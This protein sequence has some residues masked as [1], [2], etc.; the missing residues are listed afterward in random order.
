MF[1]YSVF[2]ILSNLGEV[3]VGVAIVYLIYSSVVYVPNSRVGIKEKLWSLKG[4]VENG[5]I[6]L[7]G[8][9]GYEAKLLRGGFHFL[10]PFMYKIHREDLVLVPQGQIAY[11]FARDGK[12]L[13]P[14][15]VLASNETSADYEN[16]QHYLEQGGQ[17]GPQRKV[18]REGT[19]AI[20]TVQFIV[21]THDRVYA[22]GLSESDQQAIEATKIT[23]QQRNGFEPLVIN[24]SDDKI[25][26]VTVHDGPSLRAGELIAPVVGQLEQE[27]QHNCFQ[28]PDA[29]ISVGGFRGRQLQVLVDGTY[30]LN[31]LFATVDLISKSTIQMGHVGVVISYTGDAGH[32]VSGDDYQHGELVQ[33]GTKGVW[34]APLL[35][36]KYPFNTFAGAIVEVPTTNFILK[37]ESQTSGSNFDKNLK[38]VSLITKDAFEPWLPLS[39]VV[40]IDYKKAPKV[41]QRFG[42]IQ[43]LVEQTLD[44]MV[45][46]YFKNTAQTKT[47][48]ELLQERDKIQE[49]ALQDMRIKFAAYNLELQ[50][51]L[52]G[53]PRSKENDNQIETILA[54]LRARQVAREQQETYRTQEEAAKT[55][56]SLR[57]ARAIAEKQ[58]TL[59]ESHIAIQIAENNG[60]AE[61]NKQKRQG[62]ADAA[63]VLAIAEAD[64][65][66]IRITGEA[67]A[68]R[69]ELEGAA[70]AVA[71]EQQVKAFGG[72]ELRLAQE[73]A[74]QIIK[75]IAD[76]KIP[77]VPHVLV[78]G[79]GKSNAFEAIAGMV[80]SGQNLGGVFSQKQT[81]AD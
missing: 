10:I 23:I 17:K 25:A 30:Y 15:Q 39:I 69:I 36:G 54:Q 20:N 8:E 13:A 2:S 26:I 29:F 19:Y 74:S 60:L 27:S 38:E 16:V 12:P 65:R 14:G 76:A 22:K 33:E 52:I 79:D 31:R 45:S 75:A 77:M 48:I 81:K 73:I 3:F 44:P 9:A 37:W 72:P 34:Q 46:A 70:T 51:V 5:L 21:I 55:E 80:L 63:R 11:V 32:D 41:I 78:G 42:N 47:L 57:E 56:K 64:A 24:G 35:P 43:Q 66:K 18:L 67:N 7:N 40:H 58:A 59:T 68:K 71:A 1:D 62:E 53:T 4:S 61:I 6:A 50:E 28:D 49:I